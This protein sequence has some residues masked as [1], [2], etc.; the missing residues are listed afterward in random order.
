MYKATIGRFFSRPRESQASPQTTKTPSSPSPMLSKSAHIVNHPSQTETIPVEFEH[1]KNQNNNNVMVYSSN[2]YS[3]DLSQEVTLPRGK[4]LDHTKTNERFS[5]YIVK[6]KGKMRTASNVDAVRI[7]AKKTTAKRDSFNDKV[8][9]YIN[10]AKLKI[11]TTS[12]RD[13]KEF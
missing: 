2:F 11:R 3:N 12:V 9:A 13:E 5:D 4:K 6:V 10:R 7:T 8:L 1:H